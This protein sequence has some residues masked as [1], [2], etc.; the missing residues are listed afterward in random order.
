VAHDVVFVVEFTRYIN[1]YRLV[2]EIIN[3]LLQ[4]Y[5]LGIGYSIVCL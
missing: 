1:L 2:Y 4:L 3:T 5:L